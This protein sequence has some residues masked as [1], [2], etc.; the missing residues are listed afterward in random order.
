MRASIRLSALMS[1]RVI[2]VLTHD[3]IGLGEDGPHQPI[4]HL[5]ILRAT[6][7]LNLIRPADIVETAEAWDVPQN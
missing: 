2:Y 1:L 4:E 7:N 6:P 3:S 5:A